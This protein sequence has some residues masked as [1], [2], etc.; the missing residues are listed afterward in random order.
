MRQETTGFIPRKFFELLF[1]NCEKLHENL[2]RAG[3]G[4]RFLLSF[5]SYFSEPD[6]LNAKKT[7]DF[8]PPGGTTRRGNT[9][10]L[11]SLGAVKK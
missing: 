11:C 1:L 4:T 2:Y 6:I 3:F 8:L 10:F 7:V 5:F 9:A